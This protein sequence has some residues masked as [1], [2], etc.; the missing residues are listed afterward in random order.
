MESIVIDGVKI[1]LTNPDPE[2]TRWIGRSEVMTKLKAALMCLEEETPLSPSLIG[3]PGLGKTTLACNMGHEFELPVYVQQCTM[4]IRP[5]DLIVIPVLSEKKEIVYRASSLATA[6]I[7]G[8]ICVLDEANRMNEKAWA[9]LVPLLDYRRYFESVVAGVKLT[10]H[11]D[12]RLI[13][14]MNEDPSTY[15]IPEYI[16]SRIS[17]KISV[18]LPSDEDIHL[19][20]KKHVGIEHDAAVI[21]TIARLLKESFEKQGS[22]F[23]KKKDALDLNL[24]SGIRA[25]KYLNHLKGISRVNLSNETLIK[26]IIREE[27]YETQQR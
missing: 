3:E 18:C 16:Q 20:L 14:T 12:F 10:A 25:V 5:E 27:F 17:P 2:P 7:K 4:A 19:I 26:N 23:S 9:S 15:I 22:L 13:C 8:G 21:E 24:R 1:Y 11:P 6:V